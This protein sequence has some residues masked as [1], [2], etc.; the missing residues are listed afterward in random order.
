MAAQ[1]VQASAPGCWRM[2]RTPLMFRE[3]L[4]HPQY[5]FFKGR[6]LSLE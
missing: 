4:Q 1:L 2:E 3:N 6:H 5:N